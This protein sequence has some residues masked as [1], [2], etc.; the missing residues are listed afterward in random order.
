MREAHEEASLEEKWVEKAKPCGTL[1]YFHIRKERSGGE[2]GYY[3]PMFIS[4]MIWRSLR[5]LSQNLAML[6]WS[7]SAS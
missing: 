1:S 4:Y 5:A 3:N 6:K 7:R 2:V